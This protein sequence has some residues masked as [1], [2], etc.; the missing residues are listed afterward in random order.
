MI[1]LMDGNCRGNILHPQELLALLLSSH[2]SGTSSARTGL[3][4]HWEIFNIGAGWQR[5]GAHT[6]SLLVRTNADPLVN[7]LAE[8]CWY[9]MDC[10]Y[11]QARCTAEGDRYA[12]RAT[13][14]KGY[15][16]KLFCAITCATA[17]RSGLKAAALQMTPA[18]MPL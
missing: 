13:T 11:Q 10:R 1:H 7:W 8:T 6:N 17:D 9:S 3:S 5:L 16:P 14:A 4:F 2:I 15:P 12:K 18:G